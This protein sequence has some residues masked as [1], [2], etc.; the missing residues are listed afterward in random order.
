VATNPSPEGRG[1]GIKRRRARERGEKMLLYTPHPPLRGTL[2]LQ[3]RDFH[4]EH[5]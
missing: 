1:W 4:E 3:E 2:S 5:I